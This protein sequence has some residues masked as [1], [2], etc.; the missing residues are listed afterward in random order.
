MPAS[1][2]LP[3]LA[4]GLFNL[5]L[6]VALITRWNVVGACVLGGY[7]LSAAEWCIGYSLQLSS[8][9]LSGMVFWSKVQYLGCAGTPLFGALFVLQHTGTIDRLRPA[10]FVRLA[11]VPILVQ[12]MVWTNQ[13]H[14]L[15]W[16]KLWLETSGAYPMLGRTHGAGFWLH[17]VYSY[18]LILLAV[19]LLSKMLWRCERVYRGQAAVALAGLLVPVA[20]NLLFVFNLTPVPHLD[21][22]PFLFSF[23]GLAMAWGLIGFHL[24][25]IMPVA[26]K[27][28][29]ES[30]TDGVLVLDSRGYIVEINPEA[31]SVFGLIASQV[32]GRHA[33]RV[34]SRY[35]A[36]ARICCGAK[37]V[38]TELAL[39]ADILKRRFDLKL[40]RFEDRRTR[41]GGSLIVLRDIT[42]RKHAEDKLREIQDDLERL[43]QE[44]TTDLTHTIQKLNDTQTHLSYLAFHDSLTNLANREMFL[45]KLSQRLEQWQ[46]GR[47]SPFAVFYVDV[48]RFKVYNDGYGHAVGDKLLIELARRLCLCF[49][50]AEVVARIGGD[51][52]TVL[53]DRVDNPEDALDLAQRCHSIV[54]VPITTPGV[55]VQLGLSIGIALSGDNG[56]PDVTAQE[57]IRDADLAMYQAKR[58]G[59]SCSVIFDPGMRTSAFSLLELDRDLRRAVRHKE[60][61]IHYQ[62]IVFVTTQAIAGFEA[63]VRWMH[64]TRG[65]LR[66]DCF[67]SLAE[68]TDLILDIDEWVLQE[69]SRCCAAWS[70]SA[71]VPFF[72]SVNL[73]ASHLRYPQRLWDKLDPL[74]A[75]SAFLRSALEVEITE[76][77]L[78]ANA[79]AG[80]DVIEGLL[81]RGVGVTLDDFGTGYSS[82]SYLARL[83]VRRLKIDRS[84][85]ARMHTD[86]R[87]L[88]IVRSVVALAHSLKLDVVAEGVENI[89]QLAL[90]KPLGCLHAQGHYF[91]PPIE[92][93]AALDLLLRGTAEAAPAEL[94]SQGIAAAL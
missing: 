19:V 85:V 92:G 27:T 1:Y 35:P 41:V 53:L 69:T 42:A 89:Q 80:E 84:F 58:K 14:G 36:L 11:C 81:T 22:T 24:P 31:V 9:D 15:I 73:S 93:P 87:N 26:H 44:R 59:K 78:I 86:A 70:K 30:M 6:A 55:D 7:L 61:V 67:L 5:A 90:L 74:L 64:P 33:A 52:F 32:V 21:L 65:L 63:L 51:E 40:T 23:T 88:S 2:W 46:A 68:D 28:V 77:V 48:D 29:L 71:G 25:T 17:F 43:I 54:S 56:D 76:S 49:Q 38:R 72:V 57:V 75:N 91:S 37:E 66:P 13:W 20:G 8:S 82:L 12:V 47:M 45:R 34:F 39:E 16:P 62:P 94:V 3:P 18:A 50:H 10:W 83:P 4:A 79:R 60:F